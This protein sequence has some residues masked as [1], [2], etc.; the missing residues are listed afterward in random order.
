MK[1]LSFCSTITPVVL[2]LTFM[3]ASAEAFPGY[4]PKPRGIPNVR[5]SG[6]TRSPAGSSCI[7]DPQAPQLTSI[8]PDDDLGYTTDSY[9][10]FQWY[11]PGNNASHVEFNLYEVVS[12]DEGIFQPV[13]QTAFV[14]SQTAG[15]AT[16]QMPRTTGL[17]PLTSDNYYYWSVEIYC[18]DD[19]TAVMMAEG[20]V[21]LIIPDATLAAELAASDGID[22]AAI[23]AENSL[24]FDTTQALTNYLQTQPSDHQAAAS[25]QTLLE[26]IGLENIANAPLLP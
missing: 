9:P 20:F 21:E 7:S 15:I 18:P 16:L 3:A 22:R 25:W 6:G 4:T 19:M 10:A 17:T 8:F 13:Y 23:A 26:S 11:M 12:E 24:W 1:I 5:V 14:P 2:G